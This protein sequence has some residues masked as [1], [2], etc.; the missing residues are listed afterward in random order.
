MSKKYRDIVECKNSLV[1]TDWV[2]IL[3]VKKVNE[4][5][6][7]PFQT[8]TPHGSTVNEC[9]DIKKTD[10]NFVTDLHVSVLRVCLNFLPKILRNT[11]NILNGYFVRIVHS[12]KKKTPLWV[13]RFWYIRDV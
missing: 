7:E 10:E 8:I 13:H 1:Y 6:D 4:R 9:N 12:R 5:L 3:K 2:L 11:E